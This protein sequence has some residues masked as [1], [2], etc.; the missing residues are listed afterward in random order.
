[1]R[2]AN[3][4]P[5]LPGSL[6]LLL[7]VEAEDSSRGSRCSPARHTLKVEDNCRYLTRGVAAVTAEPGPTRYRPC[8]EW[9]AAWVGEASA[10]SLEAFIDRPLV[11]RLHVEFV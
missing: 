4:S 9:A 7:D 2:S 5:R 11:S 3:S 8:R 1:M 6:S 10:H